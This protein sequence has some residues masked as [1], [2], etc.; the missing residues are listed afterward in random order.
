LQ[1]LPGNALLLPAC[2]TASHDL[3]AVECDPQIITLPGAAASLLA[4]GNMRPTA[5]PGGWP[6]IAPQGQQPA[7]PPWQDSP[8]DSLPAWPPRRPA[9]RWPSQRG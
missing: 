9:P 3:L 8:A 1:S 6:E 5:D 7:W 2:G 4:P